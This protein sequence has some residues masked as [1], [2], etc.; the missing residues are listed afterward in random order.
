VTDYYLITKQYGTLT[1]TPA[2]ITLKAG[3]ASK[4][5][6]GSPLT[7]QDFEIHKGILIDGHV[8]QQA[9]TV[10]SQTEIGRSDNIISSVII[11]DAEGN[12]VTANYTIQLI[13]GKLR[14]TAS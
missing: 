6:D 2:E 12:D 8:I 4:K 14:V 11:V 13:A 7:C 3:S 5:Y 10:G 9:V 1:I